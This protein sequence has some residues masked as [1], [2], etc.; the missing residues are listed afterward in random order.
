MIINSRLIYPNYIN[1]KI[2]NSNK[3]NTNQINDSSF[4]RET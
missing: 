3:Y 4:A 1:D 2:F